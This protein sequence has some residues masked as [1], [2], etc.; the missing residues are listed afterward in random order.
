MERVSY[1]G[2]AKKSFKKGF[3][4]EAR[5]EYE[6]GKSIAKMKQQV[7][8]IKSVRDPSRAEFFLRENHILK[9][10]DSATIRQNMLRIESIETSLNKLEK[11][12]KE[13]RSEKKKKQ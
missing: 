4:E 2:D 10:H 1:F 9:P 13:H 3:H 5:R 8:Q 11:S 7:E 12:L 6:N